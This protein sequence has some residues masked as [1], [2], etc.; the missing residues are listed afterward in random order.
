M[1][2]NGRTRDSPLRIDTIAAAADTTDRIAYRF[3]SVFRI[4]FSIFQFFA[5]YVTYY[6][7]ST[8]Q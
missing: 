6:L 7:Y 5:L 2:G 3:F 1:T 8:T 4:E